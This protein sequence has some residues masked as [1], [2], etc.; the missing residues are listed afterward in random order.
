MP[1]GAVGNPLLSPY[2]MWRFTALVVQLATSNES[3]RDDPSCV[4]GDTRS[5]LVPPVPSGTAGG[6][7]TTLTDPVCSW[8]L[9]GELT[10]T[11]G[12]SVAS[13]WS[14]L[15]DRLPSVGTMAA[16]VHVS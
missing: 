9:V 2:R 6:P 1:P 11:K 4:R 10:A 8:R 14:L 15:S 13:S 16:K 3:W 5:G 12:V 7:V